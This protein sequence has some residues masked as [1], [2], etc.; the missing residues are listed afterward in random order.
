[1]SDVDAGGHAGT[2][3][4][5]ALIAEHLELADK[6]RAE[7]QDVEA[8]TLVAAAEEL[9]SDL[10]S[11][12]TEAE[13]SAVFGSPGSSASLPS[14]MSSGIPSGSSGFSSGHPSGWPSGFPA[15]GAMPARDPSLP[16]SPWSID[17]ARAA[18]ASGSSGDA[19][20]S[21][22]GGFPSGV[23]KDRVRGF[24]PSS[25]LEPTRHRF[26]HDGPRE[27]FGMPRFGGNDEPHPS[28][29]DEDPFRAE[30][31]AH[32]R[33][34]LERFK[35]G[36]SGS[37]GGSS[38]ASGAVSSGD[39]SSGAPSGTDLP[40][41]DVEVL[42]ADVPSD[43]PSG[44]VPSGDVPSGAVPSDVPSSFPRHDGPPPGLFRR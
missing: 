26:D 10:A 5:L 23:L 42:I 19:S 31:L 27:P 2:D 21:P 35:R 15:R 44:A 8:D 33:A 13:A 34:E 43:A 41:L 32:A 39:V 9:A 40:D 20:G 1:M 38:G 25:M 14:G 6:L 12:M 22:S 17:A 30:Q 28:G 11:R 7:G 24:T 4:V 16:L 37:S 36:A 18:Q 29:D 3:E